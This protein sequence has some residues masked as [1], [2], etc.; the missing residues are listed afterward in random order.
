MAKIDTLFKSAGVCTHANGS[1][2]ITK[3]RYGTDY[4]RRVK[5]LSTPGN[6]KV[7][8]QALNPVRVSLVELPE[9]MDKMAALKFIQ[10]H[11]D[12]Q[13][14][15]DQALI[16]DEIMDRTPAEPRVRAAK[17]A[18]V[19]VKATK[20]AAPSLDSI[21]SRARKSKATEADVL[22]AVAEAAAS[23]ESTNA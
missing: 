7:R 14:A 5:L 22:S 13:S 4:V 15:D 12:F 18:K 20:Q 21:K 8:G 11:A 23:T 1:M 10:A 2:T 6:V 19:K 9:A 17:P 3:V 16:Q